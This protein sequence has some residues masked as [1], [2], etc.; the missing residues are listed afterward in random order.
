MFTKEV[1]NVIA[2]LTVILFGACFCSCSSDSGSSTDGQEDVQDSSSSGKEGKKDL[3]SSSS[4]TANNVDLQKYATKYDSI[5][6]AKD[7][8]EYSTFTLGPV[9]WMAENM[10]SMAPL[11]AKSTCYGYDDDQCEEFGRLYMQNEGSK[12]GV[13][14]PEGFTFPSVGTWK[15]LAER[16]DLFNPTFAG[17]C[18]KKDS[19]VCN[20]LNQSVRYLASGGNAIVFTKDEKGKVSYEVEEVADNGFYSFRCVKYHSIADSIEDLPVCDTLYA[21]R[22]KFYIPSLR[23]EYKCSVEKQE[24][25]AYES[26]QH[27]WPEEEGEKYATGDFLLLCRN[28][29]WIYPDVFDLRIPC[30]EDSLYE[31]VTLNKRRFVCLKKGWEELYSMEG[32]IGYCG[33]KKLG[34]IAMY[35]DYT[36]ICDSTGWRSAKQMDLFGE[37]TKDNLYEIKEFNDKKFMCDHSMKW[38]ESSPALGGFCT[39]DRIGDVAFIAEYGSQYKCTEDGWTVTSVEKLLGHCD[40]SC[41]WDTVQFDTTVYIC[42]NKWKWQK[43]NLAREYGF[44]TEENWGELKS[45][46]EKKSYICKIQSGT[47]LNGKESIDIYDWYVADSNEVKWGACRGDTMFVDDGTR[48][49]CHSGKWETAEA[50]V[51]DVFGGCFA[52]RDSLEPRH[53]VYE[54]AEYVCDKSTSQNGWYKLNALDSA[55][56]YCRESMEGETHE[57]TDSTEVVCDNLEFFYEYRWTERKKQPADDPLEEE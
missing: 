54:G 42:N 12:P 44:C 14:C 48:Y 18:D 56:G 49:K 4:G 26:A 34:T 30:T 2:I 45:G 32:T 11:E 3:S 27:C 38:E 22:D 21:Y 16:T 1:K 57:L 31:E 8:K 51:S 33:P 41:L 36:Y 24:W 52:A 23:L 28:E 15:K 25:I 53:V 50:T 55:Y 40:R 47:S 46:P 39:K 20:G 6:T 29:S 9:T 7:G 13:L 19:L 5:V 17:I 10:N 35:A 43:Q 37:C